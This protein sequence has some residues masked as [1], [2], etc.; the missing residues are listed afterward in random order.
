MRK[1][2]YHLTLKNA[3]NHFNVKKA[4]NHFNAT[5]SSRLMLKPF[6]TLVVGA[7]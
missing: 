7:E 4:K 1:N 6:D 2:G 5:F 3:K